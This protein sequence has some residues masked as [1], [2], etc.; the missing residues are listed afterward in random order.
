MSDIGYADAHWMRLALDQA[1]LAAHEWLERVEFHLQSHA[2]LA[3]HAV[4]GTVAA[5]M[6]NLGYLPGDSH[7]VITETAATLAGLAGAASVLKAG[8]VLAVVCYPGHA[9]GDA[10]AAAVEHWFAAKTDEGWRVAKYGALATRRPAPFLLLGSRQRPVPKLT[11]DSKIE[12][13]KGTKFHEK[14]VSRDTVLPNS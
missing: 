7:R 11:L 6:F 12:T 5:V 4:A 8:G 2:R 14:S 13:T 9:G 3:E 10:E 1:R